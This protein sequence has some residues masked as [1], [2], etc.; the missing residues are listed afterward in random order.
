MSSW[1]IQRLQ[2]RFPW[3]M[4][5]AAAFDALMTPRRWA[6]PSSRMAI[7]VTNFLTRDSRPAARMLIALFHVLHVSAVEPYSAQTTVWQR[8]Q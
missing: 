4:W 8:N 6:G 2:Q 3:I 7:A 5:P 1:T